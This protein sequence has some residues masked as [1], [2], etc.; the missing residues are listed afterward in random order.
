MAVLQILV[1]DLG[2]VNAEDI[3]VTGD[4]GGPWNVVFQGRYAGEQV[5][6]MTTDASA[7]S[8][9]NP[10]VVVAATSL[11]SQARDQVIVYFNDDDLEDSVEEEDACAEY[12][13]DGVPKP[14]V[15]V[16]DGIEREE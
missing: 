9:V 3:V 13:G 12:H 11:L 2:N 14:H 4:N 6:T 10:T 15:G 1:S 16:G 5:G 8:G 7:L